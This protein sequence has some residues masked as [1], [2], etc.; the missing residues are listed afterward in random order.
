MNN[1]P[2]ESIRVLYRVGDATELWGI[3]YDMRPGQSPR[4]LWKA[5]HEYVPPRPGWYGSR[6][7]SLSDWI[8][9][10]SPGWY[11]SLPCERVEQIKTFL[12]KFKEYVPGWPHE[13]ARLP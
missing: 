11:G 9:L 8:Y 7:I 3:P 13:W 1:A 12:E 10:G 4:D 6:Q 5:H 2:L